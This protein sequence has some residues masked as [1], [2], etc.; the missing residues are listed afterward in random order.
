L[1]PIAIDPNSVA[2]GNYQGQSFQISHKGFSA[3]LANRFD[4]LGSYKIERDGTARFGTVP[5]L[6]Y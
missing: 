3:E 2:V 1:P 6:Q 4:E 5:P